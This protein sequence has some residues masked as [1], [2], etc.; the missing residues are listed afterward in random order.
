MEFEKAVTGFEEFFAERW[1]DEVTSAVRAGDEDVQVDMQAVDEYNLELMDMLRSSPE[2]ALDAAEEAVNSLDVS[3]SAELSVRF[4][5]PP[6]EDFVLLRNLRSKH[7]G[8]MVPVA[9]MIKRASQVKPEVVSATFECQ[10]CAQQVVKE[11]DSTEL[12]SPYK[13]ESCGSR[14]FQ[15]VEKQMTDTQA[16]TL[17]E[18]PDE[19]EGSEQPSTLSVRLEGDLT[20]PDFQR[21]VIPGNEAVVV[22]EVKERPLK[23]KSKKF[24]MYMDANNLVPT[25]QEFEELELTEGEIED[26][27]EMASEPDI[28]DRII[29]SIA[30]SIF[31]H[32]QVKKAIALQLFGGVKKTREDGVKSRGDIHI[33]LIGEPGTGK[34][35]LL[36]F[37]GEL[38]PKGRYV[39]GKSSTGAG[40]CVTG[41][42]LVATEEGIR[43][44]EDIVEREISYPVSSETTT[45]YDGRLYS[46]GEDGIELEDGSAMWRMPPKQCRRIT[47]SYGKHIEAS[48]NTDVLIAGKNGVEWKKISEISEGDYVAAPRRL[49]VE[50]Q[51]P[52]CVDFFDF[53]NEK[54]KLSDESISYLR[55]EMTERYGSLRTA[56]EEL[57][58]P[59][60]FVYTSMRKRYIPYRRLQYILSELS[61]REDEVEIERAMLRNGHDFRIPSSFDQ[62][63]MY[64][65]GLVF[66]DGDINI[67]QDIGRV[68][69]SNSN[70]EI[71]SEAKTIISEKFDR[72]PDIERQEGKVPYIRLGLRTVATFFRNTGMASPKKGLEIDYRLTTAENADAFLRGLM[73]ADGCVVSR[74]GG[75]DSVQL[76]TISGRLAEQV[77]LMLETFGVK[78]KKRERDR[79]G[80]Y[81][82]ADG[83]HIETRSI[84]HH[85]EITGSD[86]D[87]YREKI[88]FS[89]QY[90]SQELEEITGKQRNPN[91][92]TIPASELLEDAETKPGRHWSYFNQSKNPSR[93]R[94]RQIVQ[95]VELEESTR[96]RIQ[97]MAGSNLAWEQVAETEKTG[98]KELYD[99]TVPETHNFIGNGIVTHN[100]ASVVKEESTGEFSLE[101]GAVVLAHKGMAAID[102][103]DK[104]DKQDRS[105]LHEAMEQQCFAP[106]TQVQLGDGRT[107]NI[108]EIVEP[109]IA[110]LEDRSDR[111]RGAVV[112]LENGVEL[113]SSNLSGHVGT[114]EASVAGRREAPERMLEI[115]MGN[116]RSLE[117]TPDHPFYT[118]ENGEIET[119]EARNL[120]ENSFVLAP[121][122]LPINGKE[123]E[124]DDIDAE[125]GRKEVDTPEH[126]SPALA[127]FTGYQVSDG[128]Y[129]VNRGEKNGFNFTNSNDRLVKDYVEAVN[130]LFGVDPYI[131][132]RG[133][134]KEARVVSKELK[135]WLESL[136]DILEHGQDKKI[137][138]RLMKCRREDIGLLLRAFFDGDGGVQQTRRGYRVRAVVENRELMEQ[139]QNLLHRF[140]IHSVLRQDQN[141]WRLDISRY[142]DLRRFHGE[143]GFKSAEK[144]DRL[145]KAV[146]EDRAPKEPVPGLSSFLMEALRSLGVSQSET[147]STSLCHG[148]T[149]SRRRLLKGLNKAKNRLRDLENRSRQQD[150]ESLRRTRQKYGIS[151]REV[152]EEIGVSPSLIGHWEKNG[153]ERRDEYAEGLETCLDRREELRNDIERVEKLVEN[154][155][156]LRV[157]DID[158]KVPDYDYVYDLTVPDNHNFVAEG[159]VVHNSISVSK[160]NIQATLNAET[161]ILAAGNPKLGRFD[162]YEPIPQQIEIGDTLLSRF[163]FIFPVKDEPDEDRDRKLSEQ[164]LKN[165]I[166]PEESTAEISA[167]M[168]RKYIA[169]SRRIRPDLT[170]EAAEVIQEFYVDMRKKGGGE[171]GSSVPITARQLEALVRIAE[172]SARAELSEEVTEDDAERAVDIL[173]YCLEQVGVDPETGEYDIDMVESGVSGSQRNRQQTVKQIINEATDRQTAIEIE[174]VLDR[175]DDQGVDR[176]KADEIIN[177]MQREGDLFEPEQGKVQKI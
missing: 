66:G 90:K 53:G 89:T 58:L 19:R 112:E 116:G 160:A 118:V 98:E 96:R 34:S 123:Q 135:N 131:R 51:T 30:P 82:R 86:I 108:E 79:R 146:K 171:E 175:A 155:R 50:I 139:V 159:A 109:Q 170:D 54:L 114:A 177:R 127:R 55:S 22:G 2:D 137:P 12:K 37:A 42:T 8:R 165:H 80:S 101:A 106:Q 158:S 10:S 17:E 11:Q 16:I 64:L 47:T 46:Y 35:Q 110:E 117:V 74:E 38:A 65:L 4:D 100:T 168:L 1:Y 140:G 115:Q 126:N 18:S 120:D 85:L 27:E 45:S 163:D 14:K 95:E 67:S 81:G 153:T 173:T 62:D 57:G 103:I 125:K 33:L 124:L 63:M 77:Q 148:D 60:S 111:D 113:L 147:F 9:G 169:Y 70:E 15:P 132:E 119:V 52:E 97:Q 5:N 143:I 107:K 39:V 23:K 49:D 26:I 121:R 122:K 144:Q 29:D 99:L 43:P 162:P 40:L 145:R 134:R 68:R 149:M 3:S 36:Q 156:F 92:D 28:F 44:I 94:A 20:D 61:V 7:I 172:A 174:E 167:D 141:V 32:R 91:K 151:M 76:S 84:Q 24:D 133:N 31:G 176:Q 142:T 150:I 83:H 157:R 75:S 166:E 71:L 21:K 130:L 164:V 13:C 105:S 56:A 6:E 25:Q 41:D 102:E 59:E 136:G 152:A 104:M 73:D 88:G 87:T 78:A 128:G 48:E 72:D 69:L 161:A 93:E 129:E 154:H 138:E